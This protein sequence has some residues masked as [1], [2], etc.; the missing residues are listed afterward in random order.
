MLETVVDSSRGGSAI[1]ANIPFYEVAGKT[2]TA[3]VVG[4]YGYEDNLHN[5][6]FVVWSPLQTPISL[7][8]L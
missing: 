4:D 8:L 5:S 2:G 1:E 7:L 3:H 6:F